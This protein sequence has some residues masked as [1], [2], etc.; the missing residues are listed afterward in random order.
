MAMCT[1]SDGSCPLCLQ[2]FEQAAAA[3]RQGHC[4]IALLMPSKGRAGSHC[5]TLTKESPN[6]GVDLAA[7]VWPGTVSVNRSRGSTQ[8][9]P[10]HDV[11][12]ALVNDIVPPQLAF[13]PS[14]MIS[15]IVS[16][17]LESSWYPLTNALVL[18]LSATCIMQQHLCLLICHNIFLRLSPCCAANEDPH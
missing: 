14:F 1:E 6:A 7:H 15:L 2:K 18:R 12:G 4:Q 11:H 8:Q 3:A 10:Q 9:Y 13:I 16:W 17:A 5:I